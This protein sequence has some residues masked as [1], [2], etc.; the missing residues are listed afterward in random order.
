MSEILQLLPYGGGGLV[1][2]VAGGYYAMKIIQLVRNGKNGNGHLPENS[3]SRGPMAPVAVPSCPAKETLDEQTR[4]VMLSLS[5]HTE[6][7]N[8]LIQAVDRNTAQSTGANSALIRVLE[9]GRR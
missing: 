1:L 6:A 3:D 4:L 7:A 2:F 5:Q 9:E 8:G